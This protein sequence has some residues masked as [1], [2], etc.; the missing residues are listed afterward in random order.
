MT[1]R[2]RGWHE[3]SLPR[4]SKKAPSCG[5]LLSYASAIARLVLALARNA[6]RLNSQRLPVLHLNPKQSEE[7]ASEV[8]VVSK[9]TF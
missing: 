8:Y 1:F 2:I 5:V 6:S 9:L 3:I 4:L 7:Y